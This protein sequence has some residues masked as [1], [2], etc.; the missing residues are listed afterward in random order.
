MPYFCDEEEIEFPEG[1]EDEPFTPEL[2][3]FVYLPPPEFSGVK[4][5]VR[6]GDQLGETDSDETS[7]TRPGKGWLSWLFGGRTPLGSLDNYEQEAIKRGNKLFAIMVPA[8]RTTGG[9]SVRCEYD[10]G[11]DEG[12]CWFES[13]RTADERLD[14]QSVVKR[15]DADAIVRQLLR[16]G[17]VH[18]NPDQP[19]TST[20][21]LTDVLQNWMPE[22]WATLLLGY[23]FG[24]GQY[25]MYGAFTVDLLKCTITDDHD[26]TVPANGNIVIKGVND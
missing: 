6:F 12:F 22:Q 4:E 3:D 11:N 25:S 18:S 8:L 9:V 10:G 19:I 13:L 5:P 21:R 17:L 26:A 23:G 24:T 15:L 16:Q 20:A 1:E 2:K 14:L 7:G